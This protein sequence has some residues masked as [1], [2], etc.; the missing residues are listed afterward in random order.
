M[1]IN[2]YIFGIALLASFSQNSY[3]GWNIR[4]KSDAE[5]TTDILIMIIF[6]LSFIQVKP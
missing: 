1:T 4:P 6:A 2:W 3:F 5:M